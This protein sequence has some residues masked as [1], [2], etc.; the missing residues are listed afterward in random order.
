MFNV[1]YFASEW[2]T[3]LT[4]SAIKYMSHLEIFNGPHGH[5][6]EL[7][8]RIDLEEEKGPFILP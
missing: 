2:H 4:N 8:F 5:P 7:I 1:S 6:L 3:P